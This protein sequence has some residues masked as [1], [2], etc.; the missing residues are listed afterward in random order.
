MWYSKNTLSLRGE[1]TFYMQLMNIFK[2]KTV[3]LSILIALFTGCSNIHSTLSHLVPNGTDTV[4][5]INNLIENK[6]NYRPELIKAAKQHH[7]DIIVCIYGLEPINK[8][9]DLINNPKKNILSHINTNK[10]LLIRT[11]ENLASITKNISFLTCGYSLLSFP[12]KALYFV[13]ES[14]YFSIESPSFSLEVLRLYVNLCS[15]GCSIYVLN[16]LI[17]YLQ[18]QPGLD[19]FISD[20]KTEIKVI[21][22]N[23]E[24]KK[25][26]LELLKKVR[27][28]LEEEI[29]AIAINREEIKKQKEETA[30]L[31]KKS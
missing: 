23:R 6:N 5:A 17:N 15:L 1:S 30:E 8:L 14:Q 26:N 19:S 10:I 13:P 3:K 12:F 4:K 24:E 27:G 18:Y 22:I 20:L 11:L 9:S 25:R 29:K 2:K 31:K 7:D 21:A 16:K 28:E